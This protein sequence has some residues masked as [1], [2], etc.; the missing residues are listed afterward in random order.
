MPKGATN[1]PTFNPFSFFTPRS[2]HGQ[3]LKNPS[4]IPGITRLL[5]KYKATRTAK[6]RKRRTRKRHCKKG[7]THRNH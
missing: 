6:G 4:Y 5:P 3:T 7:C 2:K 1:P